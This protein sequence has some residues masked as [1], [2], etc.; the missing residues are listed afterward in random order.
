MADL[1][2][3][4]E[5]WAGA[6]ENVSV[7]N[8]IGSQ[9]PLASTLPNGSAA[10]QFAQSKGM[11]VGQTFSAGSGQVA[12]ASVNGPQVWINPFLVNPGDT[13]ADA[14]LIGHET[15]HNLGLTDA[16]IQHDL[17]LPVTNNTV[18][19]SNKL[20]QDCFPGPPGI[21]LQGGTN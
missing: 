18:N 6:L 14:A 12:M 21:I 2:I 16:T 15:L 9:V 3:T 1:G 13:Q 20:Q 10:Q 11:T 4:P 7:L 19:I 17:G 5:D 8:G